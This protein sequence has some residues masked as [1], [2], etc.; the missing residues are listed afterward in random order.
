MASF[1]K[2]SKFKSSKPK[3]T[4]PVQAKANNT[5]EDRIR[6]NKF[7]SRAGIS[8]RREA[9]Q[10]I[11]DGKV[12]VNGKVVTEM[13]YKVLPTDQIEFEGNTIQ[14][15]GFS[16][17]LMYKPSNV[18]STTEDEKGRKTVIDLIKEEEVYERLYPVSRLDRHATGLLLL[19]NDGELAN[20]LM[21]PS[22]EIAKVY[23]IELEKDLPQDVL[24][25]LSEN[26]LSDS[27]IV[28][29]EVQQSDIQANL[30]RVHLT[31]GNNQQLRELF[32]EVG[33]EIKKLKRVEFAF[34]N[35]DKLRSGRWRKLKL[36]EI[37]RLRAI[38]KLP[39][40]NKRKN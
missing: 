25:S 4:S 32:K 17:L 33:S 12:K 29:R 28:I 15:E 36:N 24:I 40:L 22:N 19:T 39:H 6:L 9:D 26:K 30:L 27:G 11:K 35:L 20:R 5:D 16:Y 31:Q 34:L 18:L 7:I 10:L 37:N 21:S 23:E 2:K 1:N 38:V 13:G 8:S 14:Q 3:S